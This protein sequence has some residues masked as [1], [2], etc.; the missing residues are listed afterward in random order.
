MTD[1][2]L[3]SL[4]VLSLLSNGFLIWYCRNLIKFVKM[5]TDDV[6]SLQDAID[7]YKEHLTRVYGLETFYGDQTLQGLLEHTRDLS[8]DVEDF[9]QIN[10]SMLYGEDDG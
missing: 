4:L 8:G 2:I 7:S 1:I 9:I 6:N 10:T 3:V 5:T